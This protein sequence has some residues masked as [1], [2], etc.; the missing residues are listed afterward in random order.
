MPPAKPTGTL[1]YRQ[2]AWTRGTHWS[3]AICL[4]FLALTGLQIFNAH[5]VLY[6]GDESGFAYDNAILR[7]GTDGE[8]AF[9]A[10]ATI[11]SQQ[12]LATGRVI[13]FF[14]AW[15]FVATLLIWLAA[16]VLTRHLSRDILPVSRDMMR[17]GR[18]IAD[19]LRFRFHHGRT[20]GPLQKLSYAAV[21]I[22]LFPLMIGT[23]LAMS[24][25]A[26]AIAPWLT[27]IF[28]GRQT[29]RSLHFAGMVLLALF[30]VVHMVMILAAGP[31]NEMRSIL[32]GWYRCD[33]G[34]DS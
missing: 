34:D 24:P 29:A 17:L 27:E 32:T 14:F 15:I 25:G 1:I 7:L 31:I 5:P 4:F 6:L 26:N 3:W 18:D 19:H 28:G 20:Y 23:G 21:L 9:P 11:P 12:D 13:H 33:E 2:T 10:W 30:F 16:A 22:V 8:P